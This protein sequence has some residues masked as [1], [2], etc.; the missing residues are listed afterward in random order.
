[1]PSLAMRAERCVVLLDTDRQLCVCVCVCAA[2]AHHCRRGVVT[3]L[4]FEIGSFVLEY[5][6]LLELGSAAVE[7]LR[8][9][10]TDT[11]HTS[12]LL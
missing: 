8:P 1:M 9:H 10:P 12:A 11:A 7:P 3:I 6:K 4:V 5:G 2:A